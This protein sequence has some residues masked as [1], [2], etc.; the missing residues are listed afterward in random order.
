[1]ERTR[2]PEIAPTPVL[3]TSISV[4]SAVRISVSIAIKCSLIAETL[5]FD[6]GFN[7]KTERPGDALARLAPEGLD[8]YYDNVGGEHLDAALENMKDF[9]R[10]VMCG[11]IGE[12]NKAKKEDAYPMRSSSLIFS[13]RLTVRGFVVADEG[14]LA[15]FQGRN[16]GKGCVEVLSGSL[17]HGSCRMI[18]A[19]ISSPLSYCLVAQ[20]HT[21]LVAAGWR[22]GNTLRCA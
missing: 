20:S 6:A 12:Y 13:K 2:L 1:L 17:V 10:V 4:T 11:A 7:Y 16:F 15:L 21:H 8:I 3:I 22:T 5:G 19:G 9:G 18:A 14:F